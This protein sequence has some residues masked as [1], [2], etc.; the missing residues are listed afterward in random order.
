MTSDR[1][2]KAITGVIRYG[3]DEFCGLTI[4]SHDEAKI[5]N[6]V[7]AASDSQYVPML[8]EALKQI[9]FATRMPTTGMEYL[10]NIARHALA[11]LPEDLR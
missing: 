4:L 2:I 10:Y 11:A 9:I 5:V 3:L 8:T 6:L 1:E 7:I